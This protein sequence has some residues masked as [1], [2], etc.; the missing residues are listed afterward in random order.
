MQSL[1]ASEIRR[2]LDEHGYLFWFFLTVVAVSP[3]YLGLVSLWAKG[4]WAVLIGVALILLV[5]QKFRN[6]EFSAKNIESI[7]VPALLFVAVLAWCVFQVMPGVPVSWGHPFWQVANGIEGIDQ[8]VSISVNPASTMQSTMGLLMYGA[9]FFAAYIWGRDPKK[10]KTALVT[11]I[12]AGFAFAVYGLIVQFSNAQ[13]VLWFDKSAYIND[14]TATF[15]NR[16]TFAT[17]A[18][19]ILVC[20]TAILFETFAESIRSSLPFRER[21]RALLIGLD[22]QGWFL[23]VSWIVIFTSLLSSHS[24][25]GFVSALVGIVVLLFAFKQTRTHKSSSGITLFVT[26][27]LGVGA[28]FLISGEILGSRLVFTSL[29]SE[30]RPIVYSLTFSAALERPIWGTGLGTFADVF[31][32]IRTEDLSKFFLQAHNTYLELFLELGAVGFLLFVGAFISL[33]VIYIRGVISR[34]RCAVYPSLGI[35]VTF[36]IGTH[37]IVDFSMQIPAVAMTYCLVA[38]IACAQSFSSRD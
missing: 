10:A 6:D 35:A 1:I 26:L 34:R 19:I 37:S 28:L 17:Y 23:L 31:R 25:A 4:L 13:M 9:I 30:S 33:A 11:L 12:A 36:L 32:A 24:R 22:G 38:G 18:G 2:Q 5:I 7:R 16:N 21:V 3:F 29:N 15:V 14:L 20:T 27:S 8:N